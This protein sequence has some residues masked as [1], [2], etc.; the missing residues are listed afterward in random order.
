MLDTGSGF[1]PQL[2]WQQLAQKIINENNSEKVVELVKELN[3]EL[4]KLK[5]NSGQIHIVEK[6]KGAA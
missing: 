6:R 1:E 5:K 3:A 2:R 4:D